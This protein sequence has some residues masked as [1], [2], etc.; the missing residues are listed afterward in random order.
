[1]VLGFRE[2]AANPAGGVD[3]L[4]LMAP[5]APADPGPRARQPAAR[6]RLIHM[7]DI[8]AHFLRFGPDG[9]AESR[10]GRFAAHVAAARAAAGDDEAVLFLSAGDDHV[11]T[12]LDELTGWSAESFILDPSFRLLSAAGLDATTVGNHDLDRGVAVLDRCAE[13]AAFPILSAN[14]GWPGAA[15][16]ALFEVKG[17]R[18]GVIGLATES[19]TRPQPGIALSDP[20]AAMRPLAGALAPHA[21]LVILLSHCGRHIDVDLAPALAEA[22]AAPGLIVGGHTHHVLNRDGLEARNHIAGVPIL[23]A[24]CKNA[25]IGEAVW[26]PGAGLSDVRLIA[27]DAAPEPW[28][29]EAAALAPVLDGLSGHAGRPDLRDRGGGW[30]DAGGDRRALRVGMRPGRPV[31]RSHR[32]AGRRRGL[33][34]A[35][36]GRGQQHLFRRGARAG[37]GHHG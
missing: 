9:A 33:P 21:D 17:L 18:I 3:R 16:A 36:S 22:C 10:F 4:W 8:H 35:R 26:T 27:C 1:M 7:N 28:P 11:G 37:A 19:D 23:Q 29:G 15:P 32:L 34:A 6:L 30:R 5:D 14:L 13:E 25:F 24:G 2:A 20:F 12:V 31:R